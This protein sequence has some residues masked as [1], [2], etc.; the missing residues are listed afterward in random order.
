MNLLFNFIVIGIGRQQREFF[1]YTCGLVGLGWADQ[2][3]KKFGPP[4]RVAAEPTCLGHFKMG[5]VRFATSFQKVGRS[6]NRKFQKI[7]IAV[8]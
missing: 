1:L 2:I 4:K 5:Q 3:E 6:R 8:K 7:S